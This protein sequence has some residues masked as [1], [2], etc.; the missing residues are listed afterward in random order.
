MRVRALAAAVFLAFGV[1]ARG[2][3]PAAVTFFIA[4]DCPIANA[5]APEIVRVC[6]AYQSRGTSCTLAYEDAKLDPASLRRHLADYKL[7]VVPSTWDK[8]RRLADAAGVTITPTAVVRDGRRRALPWTDRQPLH[9]YRPHP[10]TGHE[11]RSDRRARR[12]AG[13]AAGKATD[14]GGARVLHRALMSRTLA[15]KT[16]RHEALNKSLRVSVADVRDK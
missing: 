6:T 4:S 16:P 11:S 2:Q 14:Y 3:G 15:T 5:Y 1:D 10:A 8:D 12:R 13:G 9:Q 7:R